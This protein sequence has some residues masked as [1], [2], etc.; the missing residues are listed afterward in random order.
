M[1]YTA[2][3]ITFLVLPRSILILPS[4]F[5]FLLP[6][7]LVYSY[8]TLGTPS[9]AITPSLLSSA[10]VFS[11][12]CPSSSSSSSVIPDLPLRSP[13]VLTFHYLT[14]FPTPPLTVPCS[15]CPALTLPLRSLALHPFFSLHHPYHRS[16][17]T[18]HSLTHPY[19]LSLLPTTHFQIS[20]SLPL[21]L[22]PHLP[23][24]Y[25]PASLSHNLLISLSHLLSCVNPITDVR[26]PGRA[27][28]WRDQLHHWPCSASRQI[29]AK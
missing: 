17:S 7:F 25:N 20:I 24:V 12:R 16:L 2:L 4:H 21:F 22:S 29:L 23:Y 18:Q 11:P 8:L 19:F 1:S 5:P 10:S 9:Y 6:S 28:A 3:L 14:T 27:R 15:I 13:P 26:V